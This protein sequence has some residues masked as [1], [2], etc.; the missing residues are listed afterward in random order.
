MIS[1]KHY[2]Q[3]RDVHFEMATGGDDRE[4]EQKAQQIRQHKLAHASTGPTRPPP[5]G[6]KKTPI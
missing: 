6:M 2:L 3:T 5:L 4:P 1:A